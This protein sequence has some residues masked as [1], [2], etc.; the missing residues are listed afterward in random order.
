MPSIR[1][2]TRPTS[3]RTAA[4]NLDRSLSS[5]LRS[6]SKESSSESIGARISRR[7]SAAVQPSPATKRTN[8]VSR[9]SS[10]AGNAPAKD[11]VTCIVRKR[12]AKDGEVDV[13]CVVD[14]CIVQVAEPKQKVDLTKYTENH[15][16]SF[17]HAFDEQSDNFTLYNTTTKP[18]VNFVME[19]GLGTCFAFGQTGSGKTFTMLGAPEV[20][21]PGL[22]LLAAD[23]IFRMCDG[24][25]LNINVYVSMMEI[26]GDEVYD[27][28]SAEKKRL[29]PREDAKKKVQIVGLTEIPVESPQDLMQAIAEGSQL[30]STS[31]TGMNEQ[32]SRSHA[33][34]QMSLRTDRGKLHGQLSF[35][36]LAGSEKGSDTAENE[37]KTRMEGAEINKSLLA[38]KECIRSMTD[39]AGYTPFR[40]SKLT[41]VLKESFVGNGRTVMIA[42]ISPAASSSMETVNTLRYAD[43]VKAIGKGSSSTSKSSAASSS[44]QTPRGSVSQVREGGCK[45]ASCLTARQIQLKREDS[46]TSKL[47]STSKKGSSYLDMS[48]EK[49]NLEN[50]ISCANDLSGQRRRQSQLTLG[51][52]ENMEVLDMEE[53]EPD[54]KR[55]RSLMKNNNVLQA[56]GDMDECSFTDELDDDGFVYHGETHE[57]PKGQSKL[58]PVSFVNSFREQIE[59][60]MALIEQEVV[61]LDKLEK[62]GENPLTSDNIQEVNRLLRERM[63]IATHLQNELHKHV[64][65]K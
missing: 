64:Q 57:A 4:S 17:D 19:G 65:V 41:Q 24:H 61:M 11:R 16:F 10:V 6:I 48:V 15:K 25:A 58:D 50:R 32:S 26:Y 2:G 39:S 45:D 43:R 51:R 47:R 44:V 60:S 27:L 62:G 18:L 23:D 7:K 1:T 33:I 5:S 49:E 35:I 38:L 13:V 21:Q 53:E 30:R 28:L 59:K 8:G 20:G 34:L 36:D 14:D 3:A 54:H 52:Y 40:S 46:Q 37:K 55:R 12:P 9:R 31:V 56:V 22:Y 42:N 63:C 29:V